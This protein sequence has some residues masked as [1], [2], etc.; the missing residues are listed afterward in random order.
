MSTLVARRP[1][2]PASNSNKVAPDKLECQIHSVPVYQSSGGIN[3]LQSEEPE[4]SPERPRGAGSTGAPTYLPLTSH[5]PSHFK[6]QPGDFRLMVIR[7]A[8]CEALGVVFK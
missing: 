8:V 1:A 2:V 5:H 6:H 7:K 4:A 3:Q